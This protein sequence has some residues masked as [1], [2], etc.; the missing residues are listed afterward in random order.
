MASL[1]IVR[2]L[3]TCNHSAKPDE[4]HLDFAFVPAKNGNSTHLRYYTIIEYNTE[5]SEEVFL[6]VQGAE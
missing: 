2:D 1:R 5:F 6:E 4:I 3:P